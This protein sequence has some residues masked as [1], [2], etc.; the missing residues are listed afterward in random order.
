MLAVDAD[1]VAHS[2]A[3]R[4]RRGGPPATKPDDGASMAESTMKDNPLLGEC[5]LPKNT[6]T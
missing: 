2:M 1:V 3:L 4:S 6:K 5:V